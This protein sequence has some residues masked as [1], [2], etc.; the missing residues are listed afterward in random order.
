LRNSAEK[1]SCGNDDFRILLTI[2]YL[3]FGIEI[4]GTQFLTENSN[5][6]MISFNLTLTLYLTFIYFVLTPSERC[7]IDTDC[8]SAAPDSLVNAG[9]NLFSISVERLQIDRLHKRSIS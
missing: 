1:R 2:E 6:F 7:D 4:L 5:I 8:V 9:R 3:E